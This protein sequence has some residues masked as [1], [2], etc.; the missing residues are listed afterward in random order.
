MRGTAIIIFL[1]SYLCSVGQTKYPDHY[2]TDLFE[3]VLFGKSDNV[4]V[5]FGATNPT[6]K[7]VDAA[8]RILV[9][10][11]DSI[12]KDFNDSSRIPI[13][14]GEKYKDY[15]RQYFAYLNEKGQKI[16]IISCYYSPGLFSENK[17][18]MTPKIIEDGWD[19]YWKISFY[20]ATHQ[21]FD[22]QVNSLGG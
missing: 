13:E 2:K 16:L 17:W 7:E 19:N 10:K 18:A 9:H 1:I 4:F 22:F 15:K 3:G 8:E 21:F 5:K 11:V 12:Q 6:R 20:T 14:I